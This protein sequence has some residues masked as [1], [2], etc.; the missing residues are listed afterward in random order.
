[1]RVESGARVLRKPRSSVLAW[2]SGS[3]SS[4]R[5]SELPEGRLGTDDMADRIPRKPRQA[6][7]PACIVGPPSCPSLPA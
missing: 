1:M 5:F 4:T 3:L 7:N 2:N 6:H